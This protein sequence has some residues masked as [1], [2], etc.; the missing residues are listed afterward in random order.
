MLERQHLAWWSCPLEGFQR[1]MFP[2]FQNAFAIWGNEEGNHM[3]SPYPNVF[4]LLQWECFLCL[5]L[6]VFEK[7]CRQFSG[8]IHSMEP[9]IVPEFRQLGQKVGLQG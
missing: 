9:A 7:I 4:N 5:Y 2:S 6:F 3:I 1:E 8:I